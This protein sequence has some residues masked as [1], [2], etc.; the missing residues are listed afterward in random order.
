MTSSNESSWKLHLPK[1]RAG[2]APGS[3][4][5]GR[6]TEGVTKNWPGGVALS[7][8]ALHDSRRLKAASISVAAWRR[9]GGRDCRR[10]VRRNC[11]PWTRVWSGWLVFSC[12]WSVS[13]KMKCSLRRWTGGMLETTGESSLRVGF[14]HPEMMRNVSFNATSRFLVWV[15]RYQAGAAHS[16]AL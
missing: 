16:A 14:R 12:A 5:G 8:A 2:W 9:K 7:H 1:W 11:G 15:L 4:P 13:L 10:C 6:Q 3:E